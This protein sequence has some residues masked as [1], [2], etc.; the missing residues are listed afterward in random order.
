MGDGFVGS[1]KE[2]WGLLLWIG[3]KVDKKEGWDLWENK[4]CDELVEKVNGIE[5]D[6]K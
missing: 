3:K 6:G 2:L 1:V 5:E 4:L